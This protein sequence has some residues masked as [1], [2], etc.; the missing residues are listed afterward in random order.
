[1]TLCIAALSMWSSRHFNVCASVPF[2]H[3]SFGIAYPALRMRSWRSLIALRSPSFLVS[4]FLREIFGRTPPFSTTSAFSQTFFHALRAKYLATR[5]SAGPPNVM[6]AAPVRNDSDVY[7]SSRVM[8]GPKKIAGVSVFTSALTPPP[9]RANGGHASR[10]N[11]ATS[12]GSSRI[13]CARK[14]TPIHP[15]G[16]W[17]NHIQIFTSVDLHLKNTRVGARVIV[18]A[19]SA[20]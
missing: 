19:K 14:I 5:A 7:V 10:M 20:K 11:T 16:T 1:M 8:F 15:P 2:S 12:A 18:S 6:N 3:I 9:S 13:K 17:K 4:P